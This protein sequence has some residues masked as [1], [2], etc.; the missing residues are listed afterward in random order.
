MEQR[1]AAALYA[2]AVGSKANYYVPYFR[3]ADERGYAPTSWNWPAFF[4]GV[5][6]FIY[7]RQFRWAGIVA[8][9]AVLTSVLAGQVTVAGFPTVAWVLQLA[10]VVG[11]NCL[12]VPLNAN[13]LYYHWVRQRL[14]RVKK[15]MPL[16]PA[17][18]AET[19]SKTCRPSIHLPLM[20]FAALLVMFLL[21]LSA[22]ID[23]SSPT[24]S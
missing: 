5:F 9:A 23:G 14:E 11:V 24:A 10:F 17:R 3:R 21:T 16:D 18:Q 7:R 13:G 4:L 2:A 15:R 8:L 12:Y 22:P 19:L 1:E 20:I 6:W